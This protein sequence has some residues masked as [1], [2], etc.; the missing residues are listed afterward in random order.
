M[1]CTCDSRDLFAYG[2]RCKED[3]CKWP[4]SE[5]SDPICPLS[6][7]EL[8]KYIDSLKNYTFVS[9]TDLKTIRKDDLKYALER[10]YPARYPDRLD[11]IFEDLW[12]R[13]TDSK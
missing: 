5:M 7:E 3:L 1:K 2:C 9:N 4:I 6:K 13:L 10:A 11:A 8:E 12:S